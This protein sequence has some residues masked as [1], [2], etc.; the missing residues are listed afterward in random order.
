MEAEALRG[1]TVEVWHPWDGAEASLFD[2]QVAEFNES[3]AW[4]I[5]VRGSGQDN[6]SE[7]FERVTRALATSEHPDLV[8]ALPEHARA[9]YADGGVVDLTPYLSDPLYGLAEAERADIPAAF[10]AQD[11]SGERRLGMPAQ[12]SARFLFYNEGW[13]RELGFDSPPDTPEEFREQACAA[14]RAL[15]ADAAPEN[16][17]QG[18]WLV[19]AHPMTPLS[20]MLAF[21]GGVQEE[22]GYRFL[23]PENIAAFRFLKTLQEDGCAWVSG[24]DPAADFASRQ[25]LFATGGL[26]DAPDQRRAFLSLG[27][28]DEWTLLPFPGD[29]Q[30][31][32]VFYGSSFVL[33]ESSDAEQLAAWLFVRWLLSP[34]NQARWVESTGLLP[35]RGVSMDLLG[36]YRD[37]NPQWAAAVELIP[38]GQIGPQLASWREVRVML[39][40][41]FEYVFQA[42]VPSGQI[43]AILAQ[44]DSTARDLNE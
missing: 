29:E 6:Y 43:A 9:W 14:N 44:M 21:G 8:I 19:D 31:V 26:E 1:V 40:D 33:L 37:S 36:D 22:Q 38:Q 11:E 32:L 42:G 10:L 4:G 2:L 7:L 15:R 3:N 12:R 18:G 5:V 39:G 23:T 28:T 17:G 13:A 20:W 16:D 27:N 34:E 30:D 25:A 24:G 35:L 41:G